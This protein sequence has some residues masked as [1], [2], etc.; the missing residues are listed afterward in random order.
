MHL[1]NALGMAEILLSGV[2]SGA[3]TLTA[4]HLHELAPEAS[5]A[6]LFSG[7]AVLVREISGHFSGGG[8]LSLWAPEQMEGHGRLVGR[9]EV[10]SLPRPL[11]AQRPPKCFRWGHQFGPGD[12]EFT[13]SGSEAGASCVRFTL[14]QIQQGC[15]PRQIGPKE[16]KPA[17]GKLGTYYATGT[18]G[19]CGQPG[20]WMVRWC[21]TRSFAGAPLC[22]DCYFYVLD[23]VVCP[24]PGDILRRTLKY[25]W[26]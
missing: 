23:S 3:N 14:Y 2:F 19:E 15:L 6:S 4:G 17:V 20:F 5:G 25:G 18:A 24:I 26:E 7:A 22:S 8:G 13:V 11:V 21:Y 9:Y 1:F 10:V 12:L 16:R